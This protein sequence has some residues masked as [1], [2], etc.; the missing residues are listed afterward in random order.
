MSKISS[1]YLSREETSRLKEVC[2]KEGCKP[3]SL[4][5]RVLLDHIWAY[6]LEKAPPSKKEELKKELESKVD[7]PEPESPEI[8]P[9]E[10]EERVREIL[11]VKKT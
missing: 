9:D 8:G 6:P 1:I 11:K 3:Y 7:P 10:V 4:V 2:E 5:K